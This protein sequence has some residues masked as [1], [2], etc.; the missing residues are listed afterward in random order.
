MS[1][2]SLLVRCLTIETTVLKL[3]PQAVVLQNV[4][5]AS[6]LTEDQHT[7]SY[8]QAH[9]IYNEFRCLLSLNPRGGEMASPRLTAASS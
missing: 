5:H 8:V 1:D 4:K 9:K 3:P 6:H 7:R 2:L